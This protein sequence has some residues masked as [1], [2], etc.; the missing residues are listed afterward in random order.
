MAKTE[1]LLVSLFDD[2]DFYQKMLKI[3]L[4]IVI[5]NFISSFLNM[6][7]TVMVGKLGETEI[8]AVGIANQYFFFF[9]MFLLGLCAGCG[10]FISQFWGKGE[11]KNI[12][13]IMGIGLISA[14]VVSLL[15]MVLGFLFP[16]K[17]MAVFNNDPK[18]I[19]LGAGYL[20]MVLVSYLFTGITFVFNFSL[21]SI[22]KTVQPMLISGFALICNAFFNYLFI[23]G[24][25]GAPAMGVEG[26]ALATVIARTV[27]TIAL[28]VYIYGGKVVLA[29]SAQ[30]LTDLSF[31]FVKKSYRVIFPVILNDIC[32]GLASLVYAAVYGRMGTQA[33]AVIQICNTVNN[34]FLVAIF[35]LSS[36]AAVMIGNSIGAGKEELGKRY[37]KRFSIIGVA[38]GIILG[39]LL[40]L[41]SPLV[42]NIFNV[43]DT[44]RS[45]SQ[46]IL[47]II[48]VIFFI[49]V[50]DVILIVGILRGGGDARQAFLIEGFTMWFIGVPLTILGAFVLG[51]PV[52]YVYALAIMEEISKGVLG[53][54]RL[55]SGRWIRN[56]THNMG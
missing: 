5:Q 15:F 44:V 34:L 54:M 29:A 22:G 32:W 7:D 55:K 38:L 27:E 51:L 14:T 46:N 16:G 18:V 3:A 21:R 40:A 48:S 26:A 37:A 47:Y 43:S 28:V 11:L 6:I 31:E 13:R 42:L 4:P 52:Y 56:V 12:K 23:F 36:A 30:E 49:R 1:K 10:V 20:R 17:I 9:N 2:R 19:N 41:T 53:L 33:V 35:G 39:A 50:L 25:W 24:K 8:A 45:D